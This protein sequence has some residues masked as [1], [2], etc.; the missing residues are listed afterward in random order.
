[1]FMKTMAVRYGKKGLRFNV[2]SPGNVFFEG[3]VWAQKLR[4]D[5]DAVNSYLERQVPLARFITPQEIAAAVSFLAG[6]HAQSITGVV[7]PVDGG[8]SL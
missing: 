5:K 2:V 6:S 7:L 3:S 8:Q 1:M 4:D